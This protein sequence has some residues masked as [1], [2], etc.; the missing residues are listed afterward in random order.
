MNPSKVPPAL[1]YITRSP[2]PPNPPN[3]YIS[4][5][6]VVRVP[7]MIILAVVGFGALALMMKRKR[8]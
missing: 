7:G 6:D 4:T 3:R 5:E 8:R 2:N 1:P